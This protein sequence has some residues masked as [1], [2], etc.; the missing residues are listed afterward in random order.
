MSMAH[1][2]ARDALVLFRV[3]C[4]PPAKRGAHAVLA[5]QQALR[6]A[7][8]LYKALLYY[9]VSGGAVTWL[10]QVLFYLQVAYKS[11][12][13][14]RRSARQVLHTAMCAYWEIPVPS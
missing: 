10:V 9:R 4:K 14:H 11:F 1:N 8:A 5:K 7:E 3:G 13:Y 2:P 12:L 6:C